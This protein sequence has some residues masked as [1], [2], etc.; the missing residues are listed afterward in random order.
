M[1]QAC[2]RPIRRGDW[3]A[4]TKAAGGDIAAA[5]FFN[6]PNMPSYGGAPR[7]YSAATY[8]RDFAVFRQFARSAAPACTSSGRDRSA[9]G[10]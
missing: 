2:G 4:Y 7:G 3:L 6:E 8:A 1:P 10:R 5:E 9:K